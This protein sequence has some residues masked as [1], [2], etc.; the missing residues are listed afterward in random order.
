MININ[1][2]NNLTFKMIHDL[3]IDYEDNEII[4]QEELDGAVDINYLFTMAHYLMEIN[5]D[6]KITYQTNRED[7]PL[8]ELD[9]ELSLR[10]IPFETII[11]KNRIVCKNLG[12]RSL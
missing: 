4:L 6:L 11:L 7:Y 3:I 5:P 1:F 10:E 12:Y 8:D 9:V 2:V